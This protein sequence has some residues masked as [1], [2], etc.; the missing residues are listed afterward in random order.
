MRAQNNIK[1]VNIKLLLFQ[2]K[3][4][5]T[6]TCL[7][8][9]LKKKQRNYKFKFTTFTNWQKHGYGQDT[10]EQIQNKFHTNQTTHTYRRI[11]FI[12]ND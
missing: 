6:K 12:Y 11:L 4:Q 7:I 10:H 2:I 9:A 5:Y 3:R 1:I 8:A